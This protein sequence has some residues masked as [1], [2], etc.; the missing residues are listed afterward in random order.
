MN[1]LP[2][3]TLPIA[4]ASLAWSAPA[5]A[6]G[7]GLE[8]FPDP[9]QLFVLVVL[10]AGLVVPVN[11]LV[12]RPILRV[13]DERAERIEGARQ[14]AA[15]VGRQADESLARY[16]AEIDRARAEG[17]RE[18]RRLLEEARGQQAQLSAAA[19]AEAEAEIERA[20]AEVQTALGG[21]REALHR[22]AERLA[23]DA[24][25]RILGRPLA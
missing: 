6:A 18:R 3:R 15:Q 12:L 4:A 11:L 21:A 8:I 23:R 17:E 14:R 13:L 16:R 1:R 5:R 22:D 7:G 24:V 2:I 19:R 10:F 25:A 20:R 9:L